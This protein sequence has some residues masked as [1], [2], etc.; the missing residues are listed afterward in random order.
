[1][2]RLGAENGSMG[3]SVWA[4]ELFMTGGGVVREGL[5]FECGQEGLGPEP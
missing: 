2:S 4:G 5:I 1:M 3:G